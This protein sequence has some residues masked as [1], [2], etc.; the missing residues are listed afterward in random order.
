MPRT[1]RAEREQTALIRELTGQNPDVSVP[2]T[3]TIA[4][5]RDLFRS[6]VSQHPAVSARRDWKPALANYVRLR[7]RIEEF[8]D[9]LDSYR[10]DELVQGIAR[11]AAFLGLPAG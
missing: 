7:R 11:L 3:L 1:S 10:Y 6:L 2:E 9:D 8:G 4:A 5:D